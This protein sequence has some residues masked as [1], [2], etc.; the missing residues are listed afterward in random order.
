MNKYVLVHTLV[1]IFQFFKYYTINSKI[2]IKSILTYCFGPTK[3]KICI[4]CLRSSKFDVF[5]NVEVL[6]KN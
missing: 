6:F 5:K 2:E 1:M 4:I 3:S